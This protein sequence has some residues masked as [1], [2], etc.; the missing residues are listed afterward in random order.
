MYVWEGQNY[1]EIVGGFQMGDIDSRTSQG[2]IKAFT[3]GVTTG[4]RWEKMD[5]RL[6][7]QGFFIF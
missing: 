1:L 7:V 3:S 2:A 6:T 5:M 4:C